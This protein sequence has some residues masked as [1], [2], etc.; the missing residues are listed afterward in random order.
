MI[1]GRFLAIP[2]DNKHFLVTGQRARSQQ[3]CTLYT[4]MPHMHLLGREIKVTLTV[5]RTES[6][7]AGG[8]QR[9]G[10]Q[11]ARDLFTQGPHVA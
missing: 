7:H 5:R 9:L 1:R 4:V 3:N 10:L 6:R 8:D 11:L 2:A